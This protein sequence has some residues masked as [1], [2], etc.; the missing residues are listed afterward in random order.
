MNTKISGEEGW[1]ERTSSKLKR[2][3]QN[4]AGKPKRCDVKGEEGKRESGEGREPILEKRRE[5]SRFSRREEKRREEKRREEK[6][7]EEKRREVKRRE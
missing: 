6:R 2:R 7:R 1:E 3:G 4:D 5:E